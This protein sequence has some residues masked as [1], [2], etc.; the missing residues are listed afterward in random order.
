LNSNASKQGSPPQVKPANA[1]S[2]C[3]SA[4]RAICGA[5]WKASACG[6]ANAMQHPIH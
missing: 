4:V 5:Y 6:A 3:I 1:T 2:I